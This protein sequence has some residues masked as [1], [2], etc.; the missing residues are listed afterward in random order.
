MVDAESINEQAVLGFEHVEIPVPRELRAKSVT[1]L[2]RLAVTDVVRRDDVELRG[3]ERLPRP[4]QLAGER[5]AGELRAGAA[6]PVH[7]QDGVADDALR[8]LLR[9]APRPVMHLQL[10][11][12]LARCEPEVRNDEIRLGGAGRAGRRLQEQER[13][14]SQQRQQHGHAS[15]LQNRSKRALV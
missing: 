6:R 13:Q 8:V 3:V 14:R 5:A 4:E 7:H 10:R 1:G 2:A 9:R 11:E 15:C 12:R